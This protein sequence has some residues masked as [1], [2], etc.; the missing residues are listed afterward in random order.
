MKI[1]HRGTEIT[2]KTLQRPKLRVLCISGANGFRRSGAG[3]SFACA[4][5]KGP[6]R[7]RRGDPY[8][9]KKFGTPV[10]L[11]LLLCLAL[12]A[13]ASARDWRIARFDTQMSVAQDGTAAVSERL[14]VVFIGS[15]HGIYRDIPIEYP[16]PHGSNY[17]LFLKVTGVTDGDGNK[18]KYDSGTENGN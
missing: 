3:A 8:S 17:S 1:N 12:V 9:D 5:S 16:G 13:P 10:A 4:E 7:A 18:L 2:E 6:P 14:D 11:A 15:F